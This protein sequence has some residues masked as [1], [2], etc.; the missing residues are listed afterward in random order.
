MSDNTQQTDWKERDIGAL[1]QRQGKNQKYLSG[2]VRL[3]DSD[4]NVVE[5]RVIVFTN[6]HKS[7]DNHPDFRVYK[8]DEPNSN[9]ASEF[10]SESILDS[11]DT[12]EVLVAESETDTVADEV[13]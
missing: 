7:A 9:H 6:K 1:W 13:L 5:Q 11:A 2:H 12:E 10:K 4:G 8:G 3:K